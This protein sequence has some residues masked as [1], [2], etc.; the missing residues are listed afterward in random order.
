MS[1][2]DT[3]EDTAS[4]KTITELANWQPSTCNCPKCGSNNTMINTMII[5]TSYPERYLFKCRDCNN[6]W[7]EYK[8][9]EIPSMRVWPNL[10]DDTTVAPAGN[11]GW[12][13]PKCGSTYSP[14]VA[15]CSRCLTPWQP[16][17]ITCDGMASGEL[18]WTPN[19]IS[20]GSNMILVGIQKRA[21]Y[22][23]RCEKNKHP[24]SAI[25]KYESF[26]E[27]HGE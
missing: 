5:F 20:K 1:I 10:K 14:S 25:S 24:V 17:T 18:N 6:H 21:D 22:Q 13:C 11:Y 15:A 16:V 4:Y 27:Q 23:T 8:H 19:S 9:F 2:K 7:T 12:V 3:F 26:M